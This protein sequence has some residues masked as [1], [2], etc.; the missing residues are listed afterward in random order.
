MNASFPDR[1]DAWT[2]RRGPLAGLACF[3]ILV[4]FMVWRHLLNFIE[5]YLAKGFYRDKF[6]VPYFEN[7]LL[8]SEPVFV[9][10]L[11]GGMAAGLFMIVGYKTRWAVVVALAS[12][13]IHLA[14]NQF[15]YRHNRYFLVLSLI[16]LALSPC[17]DALSVDARKKKSAGLGLLWTSTMIRLQLTLIYFASATSKFIDDDW[18]T[19]RVLYD[20]AVNDGDNYARMTGFW[21]SWPAFTHGTVETVW[22]WFTAFMTSEIGW[23]ILTAQALASEYFLGL[24]A[25]FPWTRRFAIWW[26]LAFHGFIEARYGVGVFSYLSVGVFFLVINT[27]ERNRIVLLNPERKLHRFW[28]WC[29]LRMDWMNKLDVREAK[30]SAIQVRDA[31][32]RWYRGFMALAVAGS[33]MVIPFA[34][35]YPVTWL[36]HLRLGRLKDAP[37]FEEARAFDAKRDLPLILLVD[38]LLAYIIY[39]TVFT[40]WRAFDVASRLGKAFD[41]TMLLLIMF[42]I[43]NSILK[44]RRFPESTPES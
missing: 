5:D 27:T 4:G 29:A 21:N 6:Y 33:A 8:P 38:A 36:R 30:V 14:L 40:V 24:C 7:W 22:G 11:L 2:R 42:L 35:A 19:G 3:R 12:V 15:W 34:V 1:L 41:F 20:R 44:T 9:C 31:D 18:R 25:W 39:M 43:A 13:T 16:L 32:G 17:G 23:K 10:V 28:A 37:V 26:A